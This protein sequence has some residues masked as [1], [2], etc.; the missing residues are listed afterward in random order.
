MIPVDLLPAARHDF[1]ESFNWYAQRSVA[2]AG[3]FSIAFDD[4]LH[5]IAESP[6]LFAGIDSVHRA[7]LVKHF[8]YRI[9]YRI[10]R[11]RVVVVAVAHAKRR[12][13]FW[14]GRK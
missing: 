1:D 11:T 2:A 14:K 7:C 13:G 4:T 6:E 3:K 12:P 10:E 9:V 5:L 8:P